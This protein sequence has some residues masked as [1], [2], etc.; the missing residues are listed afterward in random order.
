MI[1]SHTEQAASPSSQADTC[2]VAILE[3]RSPLGSI[4]VAFKK[5]SDGDMMLIQGGDRVY[6]TVE[7]IA[8]LK[9]FA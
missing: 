7:Q 6:L 5:Y 2:V 8:Q 3:L 9:D 4:D 1:Q